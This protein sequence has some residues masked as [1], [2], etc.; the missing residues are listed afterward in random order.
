M[1]IAVFY[2]STLGDTERVAKLVAEKMEADIFT[3]GDIS[4]I[5]K[6]DVILVRLL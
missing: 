3:A 2:G 6:Y 5:S 4:K 1:K